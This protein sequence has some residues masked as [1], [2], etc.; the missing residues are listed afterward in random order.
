MFLWYSP[1]LKFAFEMQQRHYFW[2]LSINS[3]EGGMAE[4]YYIAGP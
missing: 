2:W 3:V 1:F 4:A